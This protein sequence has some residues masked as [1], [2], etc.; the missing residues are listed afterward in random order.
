[1]ILTMKYSNSSSRSGKRNLPELIEA[2]VFRLVEI[3]VVKKLNP[4][5]I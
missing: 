4:S 1:M 5:Q 2:L 3:L